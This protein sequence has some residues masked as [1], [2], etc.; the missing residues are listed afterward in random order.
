MAI[1]KDF[2]R[3][4][5][6]ISLNRS[7]SGFADGFDHFRLGLQLRRG[8]AGHVED[9]FLD[10]RAVEVVRAVAQRDLRE[11]QAEADPIRGEVRKVVEIDA[12]DGNRAQ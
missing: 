2:N 9:V 3:L 7:S 11:F 1:R 10:D 5:K 8:R 12:A 6:S 4:V